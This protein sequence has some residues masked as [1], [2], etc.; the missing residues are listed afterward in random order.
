MK[1]ISKVVLD[2]CVIVKYNNQIRSKV[3]GVIIQICKH[4][5]DDLSP[6]FDIG[7]C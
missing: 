5:K 3:N 2:L 6:T 7:L 1:V 4:M